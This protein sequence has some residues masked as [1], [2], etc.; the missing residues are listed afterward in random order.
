MKQIKDYIRN[1]NFSLFKTNSQNKLIA[2]FDS[3]GFHFSDDAKYFYTT[4]KNDPH[5]YVAFGN[6]AFYIGKSFQLG[7]R[8]KRSHYYHLGILAYEILNTCKITDQYHGHWVDAWMYRDSFKIEQDAYSIALKQEV[9]IS[10]IPFRVYSKKDFRSLS[11]NEIKEINKSIEKK[12]IESYD[13][14][15]IELLNVQNSK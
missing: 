1:N 3:R 13:D 7:G 4:I 5:L 14:E 11:K 10:F 2:Q 15:D 8:W 6:N 12:L 9:R